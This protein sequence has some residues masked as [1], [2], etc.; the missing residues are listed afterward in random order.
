[1]SRTS[2]RRLALAAAL[3]AT[4]PAVPLAAQEPPKGE[5]GERPPEMAAE[6]VVLVEVDAK[7]RPAV[8]PREAYAR[9]G[10]KLVLFTCCTELKLKWP[11]DARVPAPKCERNVC[12]L[13]VSGVEKR[14]EV[15][16]EVY[17]TCRKRPFG[18]DPRL[19]FI[20]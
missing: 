12:T 6:V 3:A 8:T 2:I 13:V 5:K 18:K 16:Y 10:Q 11:K 17:G 20:P 4:L 1:M 19:I 14:T 15:D 7:G 9:N